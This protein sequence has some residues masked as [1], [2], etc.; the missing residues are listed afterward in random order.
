MTPTIHAVLHHK[1]VL[2]CARGHTSVVKINSA[3]VTY[4]LGAHREQSQ[5][6]FLW[7]QLCSQSQQG[8]P[9]DG[10]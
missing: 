8:S 10:A 9:I 5:R 7:A 3:T 6:L 2:K 4:S 1:S